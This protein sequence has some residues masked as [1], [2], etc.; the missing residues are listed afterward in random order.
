ME[1]EVLPVQQL[2]MSL[3]EY[4]CPVLYKS[5]YLDYYI[6]SMTYLP[7]HHHWPVPLHQSL[8]CMEQEVL[9]VQQ[10]LV[11]WLGAQALAQV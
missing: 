2:L 1:Q 4:L 8:V 5:P 6:Q 9:P 7:N 11:S 3:L 10:P